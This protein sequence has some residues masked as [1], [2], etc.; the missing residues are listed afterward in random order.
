M[1]QTV[2]INPGEI[3]INFKTPATCKISF[4]ELVLTDENLIFDSGILRLDF[5]FE[6]IDEHHYFKIP[7]A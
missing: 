4:K 5:D 7:T 6:G 3:K 2:E 1:S